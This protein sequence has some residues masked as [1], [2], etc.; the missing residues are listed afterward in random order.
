MRDETKTMRN[1]TQELAAWLDARKA[2]LSLSVAGPK[3]GSVPTE[4]WVP[5]GWTIQIMVVAPATEEKSPDASPYSS[6]A[7]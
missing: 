4:T 3:G 5:Q 7:N 2:Q 6:L 1:I